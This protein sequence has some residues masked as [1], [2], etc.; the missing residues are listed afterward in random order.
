MWLDKASMQMA[1]LVAEVPVRTAMATAVAE[2]DTPVVVVALGAVPSQAMAGVLDPTTMAQI[3]PI[4][5]TT[6]RA[7][8]V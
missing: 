4:P 3:P 2:A 1:D 6:I 8:A 7:Q 5:Q